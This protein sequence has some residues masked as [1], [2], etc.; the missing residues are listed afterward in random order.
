LE[1]S[2][3]HFIWRF[4][5]FDK[6]SLC[7]VLNEKISILNPGISNFDSGPDFNAAKIEIDKLQWVGGVEIHVKSSDWKA[8]KHTEDLSYNNVILHVVWENDFAAIR[9]DN[10]AIPTLELKDRID[11]A[12]LRNY[13]NLINNINEIPCVNQ[14]RRVKKITVIS[15][16]DNALMQRLNRKSEEILELHDRNKSDWEE[17][18]YQCLAKNFGFKINK[19]PFFQLSRSLPLKT[20]IKHGVNS[21]QI[22]ALLFGQA[23]FLSG[24]FGDNYFKDLKKEYRFL[25]HKYNLT[26]IGFDQQW[27]KFLR[28]RPANFPTVRIA[29]FAAIIC[30]YPR[31]FSYLMETKSLI[32]LVSYFKVMPSEFWLNHYHFSKPAKITLKG[33]GTKSIENL[34]INT[35]SPLLFA[36]GK[37]NGIQEYIDRSISF[38]QMTL[39]ENNKITRI[40]KELGIE[41]KNAGDSQ[42]LIEQYNNFCLKKKCLSCKIGTYLLKPS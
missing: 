26:K 29:Q 31:I 25:K 40:W 27:W 20:L 1:E 32:N 39:P 24:K 22:E 7:S 13:K 35:V 38:L 11:P 3:L 15:M 33:M 6:R 5:F 34:I 12:L 4:Q 42:S 17:T 19:E 8:H 28:L 37:F 14:I 21:L 36:Y 30:N 10:T 18:C 2:F 23:G 16:L 9:Q 41:V